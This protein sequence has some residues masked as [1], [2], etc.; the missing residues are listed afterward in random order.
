M[1]KII[2]YIILL[3]FVFT[4]SG[5]YLL[6]K[7]IK[8]EIHHEV[9]QKIKNGIDKNELTVFIFLT[10]EENSIHWIKKNKEFT[11]N[12]E[13]YDVVEIKIKN[14]KKYIYCLNDIKEKQ[15]IARFTRHNRRRNKIL[16]IIKK[17]TADKYVPVQ[18]T[19]DQLN[20][21]TAVCFGIYNCNFKSITGDVYSPPP[22][23]IIS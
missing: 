23:K 6:F 9:E 2:S 15:L 22:Q 21:E 16:N 7:H 3:L 20:N 13:M 1:K 12:G 11:V 17:V 8:H 19:I 10:D 18:A 14:N 4:T 5:Y